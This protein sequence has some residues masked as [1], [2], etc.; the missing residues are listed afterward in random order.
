MIFFKIN[1]GTKDLQIYN[2]RRNMKKSNS[3]L[4]HTMLIRS[5]MGG[6]GDD[7]GGAG[8]GVCVVAAA[9]SSQRSTGGVLETLAASKARYGPAC[10]LPRCEWSKFPNMYT[11][12]G[13]T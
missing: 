3:N 10:P 6:G 2:R 9:S 1:T 12:K 11:H 5:S 8:G 7:T 13:F 4:G